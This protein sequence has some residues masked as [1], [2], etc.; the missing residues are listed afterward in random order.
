MHIQGFLVT[1]V[2]EMA[3]SY[4]F[5]HGDLKPENIIFI[6][7]TENEVRLKIIDL[8]SNIGNYGKVTYYTY[9]YMDQS[10]YFNNFASKI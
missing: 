6:K 1:F 4:R 3:S 8:Q 5:F 2:L 9:G 7:D 10:K